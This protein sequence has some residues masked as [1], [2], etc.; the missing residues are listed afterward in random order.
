MYMWNKKGIYQNGL[1][2]MVQLVQQWLSNNGK[3]R[4]PLALQ[5]MR[6]MSQLVFRIHWNPA[7]GW[8]R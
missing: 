4:N 3:P 8:T 7:A 1:Q 6:L 5:S 2:A